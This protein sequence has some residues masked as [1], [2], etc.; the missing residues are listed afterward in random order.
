MMNHIEQQ[1]YNQFYQQ[2]VDNL[3]LQGMRPAT[4]GAYHRT[5][6]RI[7]AFFDRCPDTLETAHLK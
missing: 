3:T 1:Y 6:R 5:M 7:T 2:H 4:I